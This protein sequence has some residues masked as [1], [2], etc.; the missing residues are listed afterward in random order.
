MNVI[1]R[2]LFIA[3][4]LIVGIVS[5]L[6]YWNSHLFSS[7]LKS[8]D[9]EEKIEAL[10]EANRFYPYNEQVF[11]EMGKAYLDLGIQNLVDKEKSSELLLESTQNFKASLRINPFSQHSHFQYAQ[12]LLYLSYMDTMPFDPFVEFDKAAFLAGYDSDVFFEIGNTKIND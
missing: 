3:G 2:I 12:S 5:G 7:A 1:K 6:K 10:K 11:F 9:L 4:I 8:S